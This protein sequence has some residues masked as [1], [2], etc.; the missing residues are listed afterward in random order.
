MHPGPGGLRS[1]EPE[2]VR[3]S[4]V[5]GLTLWHDFAVSGSWDVCERSGRL[6]VSVSLCKGMQRLRVPSDVC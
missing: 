2:G 6:L 5:G 1:V 4:T 3:Q